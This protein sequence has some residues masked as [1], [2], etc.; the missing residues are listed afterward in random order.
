MLPRPYTQT[1]DRAEPNRGYACKYNPGIDNA[2]TCYRDYSTGSFP[3]VQC[4][5][6]TSDKFSYLTVPAA[7]TITESPSASAGSASPSVTSGVLDDV[8]VY[9]PLIQINWQS[10]DRATPTASSLL[11]EGTASTSSTGT[12][13]PQAGGLSRGAKIGIA[14][15]AAVVGLILSATF[16]AW[17]RRRGRRRAAA[18]PTLPPGAYYTYADTPHEIQS[19]CV[20]EA[21]TESNAHEIDG[22]DKRGSRSPRYEMAG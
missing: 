18:M 20:T 4:S 8:L 12:P 2:Q 3:T 19:M 11:P 21:P 13:T 16:A 22:T 17:M 9:A 6:G 15:A 14:V 1:T 5:S 10:T 7:Y